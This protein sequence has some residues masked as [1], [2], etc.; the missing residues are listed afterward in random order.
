MTTPMPS[1]TAPNAS[2]MPA[3]SGIGRTRPLMV[4]PKPSTS[5]LDRPD[6]ANTTRLSLAVAAGPAR[7][8][9]RTFLSLARRDDVDAAPI[10]LSHRL[11]HVERPLPQQAPPIRAQRALGMCGE[12]ARQRDCFGER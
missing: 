2:S 10:F 8:A 3:S 9:A 4:S 12:P 11:V 7:E 6:P 1:M 5:E